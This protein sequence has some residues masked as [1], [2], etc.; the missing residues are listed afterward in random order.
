MSATS[1]FQEEEVEMYNRRKWGVDSAAKKIV[2]R[3][4]K[5]WVFT[6]CL[7]TSKERYLPL[8]SL[9]DLSIISFSY[10]HVFSKREGDRKDYEQPLLRARSNS[11][12]MISMI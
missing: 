6:P 9:S 5:N 4:R 11:L 12:S 2:E 1:H 3:K 8:P 10:L 7:R